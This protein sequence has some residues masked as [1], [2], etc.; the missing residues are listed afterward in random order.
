MSWLNIRQGPGVDYPIIGVA[1]VGD[2][3]DVIGVNPAGDWLQVVIENGG[4]GW[5]SGQFPYTRR[6]R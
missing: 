6:A 2:V 3:F 4:S 5:V 1:R